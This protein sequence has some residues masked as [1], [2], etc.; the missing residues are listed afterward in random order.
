MIL[1]GF[2][3]SHPANIDMA[4]DDKIQDVVREAFVEQGITL[5]TIAHRLNTIVDY[6][7]ILVM[8]SGTV[9]EDGVPA[10]LLKRSGGHLAELS[11]DSRA[12]ER[13]L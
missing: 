11:Q 1:F 10:E 9:A 5:M 8:S 12:R 4:T 3:L 2:F 6:P 13:G 7:R